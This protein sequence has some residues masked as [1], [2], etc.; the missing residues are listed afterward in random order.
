VARA[1]TGSAGKESNYFGTKTKNALIRF[2]RASSDAG[3]IEEEGFLGLKTLAYIAN[4]SAVPVCPPY[5]LKYIRL[6]RSNDVAEVKKLQDFLNR[7]EG[8]TDLKITGI[9]SKTDFDAV[10]VFQNKYMSDVL[11]PWET[12]KPTGYVY[13]T[14]LKKINE[15]YCMYL[16]KKM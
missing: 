6:N 16:S 10:V 3:V 13:K 8:F 7:Y 9:Y 1:G 15:L 5:M 11:G 4:L 14:T 2:Q 12:A